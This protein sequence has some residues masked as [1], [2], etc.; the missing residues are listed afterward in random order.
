MIEP[1]GRLASACRQLR[2]ATHILLSRPQH[3]TPVSERRRI[4]A[5]ALTGSV[6]VAATAVLADGRINAV[7]R[8]L[9]PETRNV[10]SVLTQL[11]KAEVFVVPLAAALLLLGLS[12]LLQMP[13]AM[14]ARLNAI[15]ARVGFLFAAVVLPLLTTLFLKHLIGRVRPDSADSSG[16][17]DFVPFFMGSHL[18]MP[19]GHT[20]SAFAATVAIGALWPNAQ[21]VLWCY[22]LTMAISRVMINVHYPSDVLFGAL[23]GALGALLVRNY[24]ADRNIALTRDAQRRVVPLRNRID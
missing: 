18:G 1:A 10:F 5:I 12:L 11:G 7:I 3:D 17:F 19:S 8:G 20:T 14:R 13:P 21:R 15:T 23:V 24:F 6:A 4:W 2:T 9:S 16:P 22:A